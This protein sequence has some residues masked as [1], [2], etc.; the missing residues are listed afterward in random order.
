MA[1]ELGVFAKY[2]Q[3]GEVKT[4]LAAQLG[5]PGAAAFHRAC[6]QTVV[7]RFSSVADR[8]ILAF[9]P[10]HREPEFAALARPRWQLR[11]QAAGDLG[12][13]MSSFFAEAFAAGAR[14]VVLIGSDS[15]TMPEAFLHEAFDRLATTD[16]VLGPSDDG[17][18]YLIGLTRPVPSIFDSIAWST[19]EVCRQTLE[20]L[21]AV[22][23]RCHL[24]PPWYDIDTPQDLNRLRAEL[25]TNSREEFAALR[26]FVFGSLNN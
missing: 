23:C 3:P 16:A 8:R 6:V 15:P 14:A 13:R 4:R 24:L 22:P 10:D 5:A 19:P 17:G 25:A 7:R 21:E 2:W 9:S 26:Q 12:Q 1:R 18:Y 20:R 11:P